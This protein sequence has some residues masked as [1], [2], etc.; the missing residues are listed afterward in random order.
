MNR[1]SMQKL[2]DL[3]PCCACQ[4]GRCYFLACLLSTQC[5]F[6]NLCI[7]CA[8]G[9]KSLSMLTSKTTFEAMK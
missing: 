7:K 3:K 8:K 4:N 9:L 6:N 1:C 5:E 2:I